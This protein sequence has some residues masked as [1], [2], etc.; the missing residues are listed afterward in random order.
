MSAFMMLPVWRLISVVPRGT[1]SPYSRPSGR[2]VGL[3]DLLEELVVG[4]E[5]L[6]AVDEHLQAG[7]VAGTLV[8]L[9]TAQH[10]AEPPDLLELPMLEQKLLVAGGGGLDVDRRID[11]PVGHPPV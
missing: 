1:T 2:N 3:G 9:E 7:G 5:R 6:Q 11:P 10:P 8:G 4:P